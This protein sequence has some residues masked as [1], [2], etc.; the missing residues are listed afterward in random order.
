MKR[1]TEKIERLVVGLAI[2]A[3]AASAMRMGAHIGTTV[4]GFLLT[5]N[6]R[7]DR[8]GDPMWPALRHALIRP[9]DR[10]LAV[11][12]GGQ[13]VPVSR[14]QEAYAAV[15][16][17]QPG[18]PVTYDFK[19]DGQRVRLVVPA[20][21][22]SLLSFLAIYGCSVI[23]G[24]LGFALA[25]WVVRRQ[26]R[27]PA[28]WWFLTMMV[29]FYIGDLTF[30]EVTVNGQL[31]PLYS[32]AL[33]LFAAAA[34]NFA[35]VFPQPRR[36]VTRWPWL[37]LGLFALAAAGGLAVNG[38]RLA[39]Q[40]RRPLWD[41]LDPLLVAGS[42]L[43]LG[44]AMLQSYW[45]WPEREA[46]E[47]ARV[48]LFGFALV[49]PMLGLALLPGYLTGAVVPANL[50]FPLTLV[51]SAG[52]AYAIVRGNL[53]E[54]RHVLQRG[55]LTMALA[56]PWALVF[57]TAA[58]LLDELL[59][60]PGVGTRALQ[61]ALVV[62]AGFGFTATRAWLERW[63]DRL[64]FRARAAYKPTV[65]DLSARFTR[66]LRAEEVLRRTHTIVAGAMPVTR[67]DIIRIDDGAS[68]NAG[69]PALLQAEL[70]QARAPLTRAT[71]PDISADLE[72]AGAEV[73]V[74][75]AFEGHLRAAMLLGAKRSAELY[76]SEDLD[77]LE[78]I[79]NQAAIALENASSFEQLDRLRQNL[80]REVE[81]RTREL[82]DTQVQ[83]VH[84]EKMASL[85]QL[86]AGVAHELNNP[87]GAVGGNLAVLRDYVGRLREA[88]GA[89][90]A[91]APAA[92]E[93]FVQ[94]RRRL[95]LD[96]IVADLDQLLATCTEGSE[97]A[98]RI[99]Q[100]LRTFSRL[101]EAELKRVDLN[102]AI[103]V[104]L[105]LLR[106]RLRG[107]VQL[108]TALEP[109]P[110]VECYASQLNQV[111]LNLLTN[112]LDAVEAAGGGVVRIR[113]R[114]LPR[115]AEV[116]WVEITVQDT[117]A[118]V[119]AALRD[120]IFDPF[121]TTKPVGKGTGLGL[122]ISYS[123][124]AKHGGQLVLDAASGPGCTF[125]IVL[126]A[127]PQPALPPATARP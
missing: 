97:R 42:Q 114:P 22:F 73:A 75:I 16:G 60:A 107:G 23:P 83:L 91:A 52:L 58:L 80:E 79:A 71:H 1:W 69:L 117:G 39:G 15:A 11:Y 68:G 116:D 41:A 44:A 92:H 31:Q 125:R 35:L 96:E 84:A 17:Y 99:V 36:L 21:R 93:Q 30:C 82:K 127:R 14:P 9:N 34:V 63:V 100:D 124:V 86:V 20:A 126:P 85:G 95:D 48:A 26:S 67:A 19:R 12:R 104:T 6:L 28:S 119:P 121:F 110:A 81:A 70:R 65:Q 50:F 29:L 111:F 94:V 122:S 49:T 43:F 40:L 77:L 13:P 120:K 108:E 66:L 45:A 51:F 61:A 8:V 37:L 88:L 53:F 109:L 64:F 46:R 106:H 7:F 3:A 90:E 101:D 2:V 59:P 89:Y 57:F 112:A 24:L 25:W 55:S 62:I 87:L 4:P 27:H 78:T 38:L 18:E 54:L 47:R 72:Q 98:R 10:L 115:Q 103:G 74:P 105:D 32:L 118:G 113:S 33:F 5:A 102:A 56:I 123:I 76:T